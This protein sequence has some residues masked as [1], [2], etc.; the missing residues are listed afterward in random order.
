MKKKKKI[1]TVVGPTATG[2]TDVAIA[3]AKRLNG[4]LI[5]ADSMQ[6][7]QEMQIGTAKPTPA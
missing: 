4:E 7:Y 2:K 1:I 5:S 3:L 6:I